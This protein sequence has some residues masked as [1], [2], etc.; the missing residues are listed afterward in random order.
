ML[1]KEEVM[2]YEI[3]SLPIRADQVDAFTSA[4]RDVTHL[5]TRAKGY[6]GHVLTQGIEMPSHFTL[7]VQWRTLEDHTQGFEPSEDH[8]VFLAGLQAYLSAEPTVDHVRAAFPSGPI[9]LLPA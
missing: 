8:Q 5:L 7:I 4:F 9:D 3:A 1:S 2:V 6:Q